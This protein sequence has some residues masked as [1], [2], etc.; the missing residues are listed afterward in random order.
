LSRCR[1]Q[2]VVTA[3]LLPLNVTV[4]ERL[5]GQL[6]VD[7]IIRKLILNVVNHIFPNPDLIRH[8]KCLQFVHYLPQ[9]GNNNNDND[10]DDNNDDNGSSGESSSSSGGGD[11]NDKDN[12]DN[13]SDKTTTTT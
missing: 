1:K 3:P 4:L 10:R 12:N 8:N 6:F 7:F 5:W 2:W 13:N 11:S 9:I